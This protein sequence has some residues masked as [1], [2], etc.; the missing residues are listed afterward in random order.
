MRNLLKA[1]DTGLKHVLDLLDDLS[2][3]VVVV[4][5][6][7]GGLLDQIKLEER[8]WVLVP[9]K[10]LVDLLLDLLGPGQVSLCD[11]QVAV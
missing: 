9:R 10:V 5:D 6:Q 11:G 1:L 3:V 7:L 2:W 8:L 4:R